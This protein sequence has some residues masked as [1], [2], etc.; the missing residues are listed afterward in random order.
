MQRN[1]V[2]WVLWF[3][4]WFGLGGCA[5][6]MPSRERPVPHPAVTVDGGE[7]TQPIDVRRDTRADLGRPASP[8]LD[9]APVEPPPDLASAPDLAGAPDLAAAPD[10]ARVYPAY[11]SDGKMDGDETDVDCGGGT[12][13]PCPAGDD[14]FYGSD[15]AS[16][17]CQC[18]TC[19]V[20]PPPHC[21]DGVQ[22]SDEQGV[23]CGGA[24]CLGCAR[25]TI[26]GTTTV[27][28]PCAECDCTSCDNEP[29]VM[30]CGGGC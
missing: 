3:A 13:A 12:C 19:R 20:L 30:R 24:D 28:V 14:C 21:H 23:D 22:D 27:V 8:D 10:L 6:P 15:C 18:R 26:C 16:G 29:G 1:I 5:A 11:C 25:G 17:I 9:P 7:S 2:G 4:T